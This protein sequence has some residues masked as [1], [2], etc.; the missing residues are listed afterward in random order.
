M[1][2]VPTFEDGSISNDL[3]KE[4][5]NGDLANGLGNLTSRIL[6]LVSTYEV[7]AELEDPKDIW[8][9]PGNP[10]VLDLEDFDTRQAIE[11]IW[12]KIA[13]MDRELQESAPWK[14][15]KSD[16]SKDKQKGYDELVRFYRE[17]WW[18]TVMLEPFMPETSR[19]IAKMVEKPERLEPL[20]PRKD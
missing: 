10:V 16:V 17:L 6:K 9:K 19:R 15:L 1:R 13:T 3:V 5:Y 14:L 7:T 18:V 4:A 11:R 8:K 2:K 12:T 20:F